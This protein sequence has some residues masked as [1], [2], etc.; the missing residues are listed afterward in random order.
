MFLRD[1][2]YDIKNFIHRGIHGWAYPDVWD[3]DDY[4]ARIIPPMVRKIAKD[5]TGCPGELW[6]AKCVNNECKPWS[7]ILEEI[8]QGFEAAKEIKDLRFH[9]MFKKD[10][11]GKEYTHEY[12]KEKAEQLAKK[13]DRGLMLF[14]KYYLNLWD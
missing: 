2:Y 8:A 14:S 12:Q 10:K 13:L 5:G 7:D 3:I 11:D 4:L 1:W 6:D 9:F